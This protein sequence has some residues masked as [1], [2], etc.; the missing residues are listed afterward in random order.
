M[1]TKRKL[2]R[3]TSNFLAKGF[4]ENH[5]PLVELLSKSLRSHG[6]NNLNGGFDPE[7]YDH[8]YRDH[9][10]NSYS[11]AHITSLLH[12]EKTGTLVAE[13][14]YVRTMG[15]IDHGSTIRLSSVHETNNL[16]AKNTTTIVT[17][18]TRALITPLLISD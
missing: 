13:G 8:R 5:E 2:H 15:K 1:N 17:A 3:I 7:E 11:F 10:K 14:Y 18:P 12:S 6:A 9:P 4:I 16:I